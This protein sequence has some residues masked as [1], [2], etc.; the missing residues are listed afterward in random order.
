MVCTLT[1]GAMAS[2]TPTTGPEDFDQE[3]VERH[4]IHP[5]Y[6][7]FL[8]GS[9]NEQE[10]PGP[11]LM[12]GKP[13]VFVANPSGRISHAARSFQTT[14][15]HRNAD[16]APWRSKF[17]TTLHRY[18][19][20][21]EVDSA[22]ISIQEYLPSEEKLRKKSLGTALRELESKP[23]VNQA[24]EGGGNHCRRRGARRKDQGAVIASH[25]RRGVC[26]SAGDHAARSADP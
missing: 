14:V 1:T 25:V 19:K 17:A 3:L 26:G 13:V 20:L 6:G 12:P 11:Y 8:P 10:A 15:N 4:G 9:V 5:K 18:C 24:A 7:I 23:V 16:D 2:T 21:N 22:D